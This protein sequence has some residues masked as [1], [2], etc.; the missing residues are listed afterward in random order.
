MRSRS[1]L[2]LPRSID[3]TIKILYLRGPG[4]DPRPAVVFS[5]SADEQDSEY[6]TAAQPA[7]FVIRGLPPAVACGRQLHRPH[8]TANVLFAVRCGALPQPASSIQ[9]SDAAIFTSV[10]RWGP[11]PSRR[12]PFET[13]GG[14]SCVYQ[15]VTSSKVTN[16]PDDETDRHGAIGCWDADSP[17]GRHPWREQKGLH[18]GRAVQWETLNTDFNKL[19]R[20]DGEHVP[21]RGERK[22][23]VRPSQ[24][25]PGRYGAA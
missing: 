4:I 22:R 7:G 19:T 20:P 18:R 11:L 23:L 8:A 6:E 10:V 2:C 12:E 5:R 21:E 1:R 15:R 17:D 14:V 3:R 16:E 9:V 24:A 13:A 25:G